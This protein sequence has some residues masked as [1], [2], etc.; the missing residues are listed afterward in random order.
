M[1]KLAYPVIA[2]VLLTGAK[3]NQ[4]TAPDVHETTCRWS[5]DPALNT[6]PLPTPAPDKPIQTGR[7][8]APS[9]TN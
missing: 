5:N 2:L 7:Q 9:G 8:P 6:C 3:C 4:D 1:R